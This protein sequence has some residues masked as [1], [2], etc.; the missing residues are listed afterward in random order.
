MNFVKK[1]FI[2]KRNPQKNTLMFGPYNVMDSLELRAITFW[3][4]CSLKSYNYF[5]KFYIV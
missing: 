2:V 4:L 1:N 3:D 5:L